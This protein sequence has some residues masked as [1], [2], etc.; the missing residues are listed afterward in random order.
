MR[1]I[2]LLAAMSVMTLVAAPA[3]AAVATIPW[4]RQAQNDLRVSAERL[5][6]ATFSNAADAALGENGARYTRAG[7]RVAAMSRD[8]DGLLAMALA[9]AEKSAAKN[10]GVPEPAETEALRQLAAKAD[11]MV[12]SG[13]TVY[14]DAV[15]AAAEHD[16]AAKAG[17]VTRMNFFGEM[18]G[19]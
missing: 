18:F 4:A 3:S 10:G 19:Y 2:L 15:D 5:E 17:K 1:N 11:K 9:K 12:A 14:S 8:L 16:P 7:L 13:H 6:S